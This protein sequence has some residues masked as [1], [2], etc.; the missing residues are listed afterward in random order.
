MT[1]I[2]MCVCVYIYIYTH[3]NTHLLVI[4][5][6]SFHPGRVELASSWAS[7]A[8]RTITAHVRQSWARS[9]EIA[10][11]SQFHRRRPTTWAPDSVARS[12]LIVLAHIFSYPPTRF[13]QLGREVGR[14]TSQMS[15]LSLGIELLARTIRDDAGAGWV[16]EDGC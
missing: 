11:Q 13:R 4:T 16:E 3:T 5:C 8:S 1:Y 2:C 7:T 12:S 9:H 6:I 10:S 14:S 15:S